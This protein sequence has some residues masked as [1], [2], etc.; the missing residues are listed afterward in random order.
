MALRKQKDRDMARLDRKF[1]HLGALIKAFA[2]RPHDQ[3]CQ[4]AAELKA[5]EAL[6]ELYRRELIVLEHPIKKKRKRV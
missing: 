6:T 4:W 2:A 1:D 5:L 3:S